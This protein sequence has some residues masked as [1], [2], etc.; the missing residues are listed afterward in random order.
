MRLV[1]RPHNILADGMQC[2]GHEPHFTVLP[3]SQALERPLC[4]LG[5]LLQSRPDLPC[6]LELGPRA[7][8]HALKAALGA[9][10]L[11]VKLCLCRCEVFL[12][13]SKVAGEK[14]AQRYD[15]K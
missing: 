9:L 12:S 7:V 2:C 11:G 3:L 1:L 10:E 8:T 13:R 14:G 4:A 15:V 5:S 6:P